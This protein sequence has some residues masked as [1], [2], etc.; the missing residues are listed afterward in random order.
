MAITAL[1]L[2]RVGPGES[3]S[4]LLLAAY[5][6]GLALPLI[7][8]E[9]ESINEHNCHAVY[10]C[11][12]LVT[13]YAFASSTSLDVHVFSAG[14]GEVSEFL[15]LVRGAFAVASHCQ[16]WLLAG[17]LGPS[18]ER[19]LDEN[20]DFALNPE[21]DLLAHL[22][23]ILRASGNK[24]GEVCCEALNVLRNLL[25][26]AATPDQTIAVKT[27]VLSWPA[28]IPEGYLILVGERKAEALVVLAH[29]CIMLNMI[30]SL[31]FMR[32]S[33]ARLMEQCRSELS[34]EWHPHIE[35][36]ASVVGLIQSDGLES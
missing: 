6:H 10:A 17:P 4:N 5:H 9:L 16:D 34:E 11:G 18:M 22:L 32:G 27:L 30:D 28:E 12:H 24:E 33:A 21:D 2:S 20:P 19:P 31:W 3:E 8:S 7:R 25:A 29:Y 35:W 26:M 36:P 1:H 13:K 23:P 15:P 14:A